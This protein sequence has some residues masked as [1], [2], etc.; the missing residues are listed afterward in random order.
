MKSIMD[1]FSVEIAEAILKAIMD[2]MKKNID[3]YDERELIS[4]CII[5][6]AITRIVEQVSE[7]FK[8]DKN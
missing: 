1:M 4:C 2:D 8:R 3:T 6:D 5:I 7:R